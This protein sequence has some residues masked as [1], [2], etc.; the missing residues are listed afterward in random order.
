MPI[1]KSLKIKKLKK[2][3]NETFSWLLKNTEMKK[4]RSA[5]SNT[6]TNVTCGQHIK[7]T[8]SEMRVTF[9]MQPPDGLKQGRENGALVNTVLQVVGGA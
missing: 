3:K 1:F 7:T 9:E 5:G 8:R 6:T 4:E 2:Q